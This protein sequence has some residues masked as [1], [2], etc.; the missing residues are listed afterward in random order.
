MYWLCRFIPALSLTAT[1]CFLFR[2]DV[3]FGRIESL[4]DKDG[5]GFVAI[6]DCDDQDATE[7]PGLTWYADADEDGWGDPQ[8]SQGCERVEVTD[9][10]NNTDCD[11]SDGDE[12]PGVIWYADLDGDTYG[13]SEDSSP[14]E[15]ANDSDVLNALDCD[16]GDAGLNPEVT[17]Y[18]DEDEDSYGDINGTG[19][20]CSP[21]RDDD[22][23][24]NTD[25]NDN[26]HSVYPGANEVCGDGVDSD[27]DG[28]A[29]LC[30]IEGL[31]ELVMADA[32]L[33]GEEADD[34]AGL[35][36]SGVGD[37]N[38]DGL[39]DLLVGAPMESTG[40]SNAG[41]AYLVLSSA[42]GVMDL[43]TST[44]KLI[45]EEPGDWA[46]FSVA[47]AGDVNG[48][49]VPDLA[50][51]APYTDDDAGTAYLV[52]GPSGGTIDL[53]L[54][55][56]QMH[57]SKWQTAGW[58]LSGVGDA[59]GDGKDD[60]LVGAPDWDAGAYLVLGPM[61]GDSHLSD[62]EAV[63]TGEFTTGTSVSG[64]DTD[65]D[66]IADLLIGA[67]ERG[68]GQK[69]SAFLLLGPVSGTVKLNS[70]D[71]QLKGEEDLDHAGS[72]VSMA[73][74]VNGDGKADLLIGAPDEAS[75]DNVAGAAY[76][77]LSPLS[78]TTSLSAAEA[79]LFGT[80]AYDH[81]GSAVA[82]AG[83]INGDG[84]ADLL[85]GAADED[86]NGV[87]AGSAYLV[88]GPVSGVLDLANAS[89]Q[90][91]GETASDRAGI[92]LAGPGDTNGDG[93]DDVLIG[94]SSQDAGGVDGGACYL[95]LGGGL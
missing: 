21:V 24:N 86:S 4:K 8:S 78:G 6:D 91:V 87:S 32:K 69:G 56:A 51:G 64:G 17:W 83:D 53:Q 55:A 15:R 11:D 71:A 20:Q 80:E 43:S 36:V 40:G 54:A 3:Y 23:D 45:G 65:G 88:L 35:S 13:N 61:S 7:Y 2:D 12:Y 63:V 68:L 72:A 52:L 81:A 1:S 90:L 92:S 50:V 95:F 75:N 89:A 76:L 33:V 58:S 25:C 79:K 38:G 85:I 59:N 60:L 74:D 34:N 18:K 22:V 39:N 29:E 30:R 14:C 37:V 5:D 66:G 70:A 62:A 93:A 9:V 10:A 28:A 27:C 49:G 67:P 57:G 46:G 48:D 94:A 44:A 19:S 41:A 84:L 77:V 26:D 31:M 47:G 42:S 73:G 82:A 16:D